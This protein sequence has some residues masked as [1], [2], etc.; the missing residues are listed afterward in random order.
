MPF[1]QSEYTIPAAYR[2]ME[3]L[4]IVFWLIKD[5]SWCMIWKPLGILMIFPT[6]IISIIIAWR[7]RTMKSEL[8]H[9]LAITVWILANSYWMVSE[10]L[11]FDSVVIAG[12]FTFRHLALIPFV[13]GVLLLAYYYMIWYPRHK[14]EAESGL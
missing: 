3:N 13:T 1:S 7:T 9:N 11:H 14:D 8:Y 6:L 10:F 4:H 12:P 2:R 5:I